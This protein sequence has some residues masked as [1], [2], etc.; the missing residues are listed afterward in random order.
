MFPPNRNVSVRTTV[1]SICNIIFNKCIFIIWWTNSCVT[2]VF[3]VIA[4]NYKIFTSICSTATFSN[5]TF[6]RE[7]WASPCW[8]KVNT[9]MV[10]IFYIV[11]FY[12]NVFPISSFLVT[13][14]SIYNTTTTDTCLLTDW[15]RN[16][17]MNVCILYINFMKCSCILSH[18]QDTIFLNMII[19]SFCMVC[20]FNRCDFPVFLIVEKYCCVKYTV[21]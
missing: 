7:C 3:A 6:I 11:S 1:T 19:F 10:Y 9:V 20:Y 5:S 15:N 2:Y 21:L 14:D 18:N 13:T 8:N 4:T 17:V 16:Y 12:S